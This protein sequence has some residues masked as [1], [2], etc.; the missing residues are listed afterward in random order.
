MVSLLV[1]SDLDLEEEE[2]LDIEEPDEEC[3]TRFSSSPI[4][5]SSYIS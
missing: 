5:V 1:S 4:Y 2:L 3:M